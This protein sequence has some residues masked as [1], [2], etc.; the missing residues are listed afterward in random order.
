M[1][2][3]VPVRPFASNQQGR[4]ATDGMEDFAKSDTRAAWRT[5]SKTFWQG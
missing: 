3:E 5:L 4:F 2:F 1:A